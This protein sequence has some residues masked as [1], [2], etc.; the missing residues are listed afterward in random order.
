MYKVT[1]SHDT[2]GTVT[3]VKPV[4]KKLKSVTIPA[5]VNING[6]AFKVTAISNKAFKN[7]KKLKSVTIGSNVKTIGKEAFSGCKALKKLTVKSKVVKKV[8]K[9]AFKGIHKTAKIKLPKLNSKKFNS[10]KKKFMK[11]GQPNTVKITK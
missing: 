11:K 6:Y 5:T 4:N 10:Y 7:N 2:K 3:V 9:N 8:N 1:K